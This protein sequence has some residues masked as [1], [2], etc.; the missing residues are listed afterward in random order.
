MNLGALGFIDE[1]AFEKAKAY[2]INLAGGYVRNTDRRVVI[3]NRLFLEY[4]M[5]H[6]Y[7]MRSFAHRMV[8]HDRR[9]LAWR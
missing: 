3:G 8:A 5:K 2:G 4:G 9:I 7:V 6:R 1:V